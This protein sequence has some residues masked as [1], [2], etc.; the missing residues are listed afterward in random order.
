VIE[1]D[2]L[3]PSETF[4]SVLCNG[5][6]GFGVDTRE[7]QVAALQAMR[8]ILKPGGRLLLGWNTERVDDPASLDFVRGAFA[9]DDLIGRGALWEI[10]EAKYVYR[11]LRRRGE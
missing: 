2:K 4:D 3:I 1:I 9:G 11:F 7:A 10:P 6:F 5:V 8:K